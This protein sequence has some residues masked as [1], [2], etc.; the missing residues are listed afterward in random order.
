MALAIPCVLL[1]MT[2]TL[3]H[4]D[5]STVTITVGKAAN[6]LD[7]TLVRVPVA[8][9][10]PSMEVAT[11]QGGASLRQAVSGRIA[12]GSGRPE[13]P[14]VCDGTPHPNSYLIW[15]DTTSPAP[16]RVGNATA[17]ISA[18]LCSPTFTCVSGGSGVQVIRVKR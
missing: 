4:A 1:G 12:F 6:L 10:C 13:K 18:Y 5:E 17:M 15:V 16:F 8:L 14:V 11:N 7:P 9:T 2:S 3:A